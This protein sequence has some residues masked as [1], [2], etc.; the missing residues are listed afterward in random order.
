MEDTT[1]EDESGVVLFFE[2][3][4]VHS[5]TVL[6]DIERVRSGVE[7]ASDDFPPPGL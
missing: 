4:G 1:G 6:F 2:E 7:K 5:D 3:S